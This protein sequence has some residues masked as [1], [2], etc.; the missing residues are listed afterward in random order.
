MNFGTGT[1]KLNGI[2]T[3]GNVG[4]NT[5]SFNNIVKE[6][7]YGDI[8]EID[9]SQ[10]ENSF[11]TSGFKAGSKSVSKF[12]SGLTDFFLKNAGISSKVYGG[13]AA[14][15]FVVLAADLI[16]GKSLDYSLMDSG[17]TL[18]IQGGKKFVTTRV[19]NIIKDGF[20]KI[21]R[22]PK[23]ASESEVNN[24]I[25][26]QVGK[27][28]GN[29]FSQ[30]GAVFGINIAFNIVGDIAGDL[31][32]GE[33]VKVQ[34]GT[35]IYKGAVMCVFRFAGKFVGTY[36][37]GKITEAT[38]NAIGAYVAETTVNL[39]DTETA[40][41]CAGVAIVAG[42]ALGLVAVVAILGNPVGWV[43]AVAGVAILIGATLGGVIVYFAE[44]IVQNWD[45][46]VQS[47]GNFLE[48]IVSYFVGPWRSIFS[49]A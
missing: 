32:K 2:N 28:M 47:A 20:K 41:G 24:L 30:F 9:Y 23:E 37:G 42:G 16:S 6:T 26:S 11:N 45:C 21:V 18:G 15:S 3:Y 13:V 44:K 12:A 4:S 48:N 38:F 39:Y 34:F 7:D 14:E 46:I 49:W 29:T 17:K 25:Y 33:D 40:R 35:D 43:A 19:E 5:N 27:T 8:E 22:L 10:E 36:F 1:I 31:I